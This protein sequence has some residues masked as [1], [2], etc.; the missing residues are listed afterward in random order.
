MSLSFP[1]IITSE[2][3]NCLSRLSIC[4]LLKFIIESFITSC[5]SDILSKVSHSLHFISLID[6]LL[7]LATPKQ[8]VVSLDF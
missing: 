1:A 7:S 6:K 4:K 3:I 5:L 2:N 8:R